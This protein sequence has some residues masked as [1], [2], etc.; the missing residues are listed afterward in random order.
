MTPQQLIK[1]LRLSDRLKKLVR[2]VSNKEAREALGHT[3]TA[4]SQRDYSG[5]A[6]EGFDLRGEA[7]G[8]YQVRRDNPEIDDHGKPENKYV[9]RPRS[10]GERWINTTPGALKP[11]DHVFVVE[12]PK[13]LLAV[14]AYFERTKFKNAKVIDLNGLPGWRVKESD[15]GPSH[16]NPDLLLLKGH[17]VT[18]LFDSNSFRD[19]LKPLVADFNAF[20]TEIGCQVDVGRIPALEGVNGPD[21]LLSRKDDKALSGVL[22]SAQ[23]LWYYECPAVSDYDP[24]DIKSDLLIE[25]LVANRSITL[26]ASPSENYKSMIAMC[27]SRS[28]LDKKDAFECSEFRVN[29]T[30]PGVLY[31]CPDMSHEMTILYASKFGL[32]GDAYKGRFRIRTMKQGEI[33]GPDHPTIIQAARAG[34]FIVLDTMNYFTLADDDN[35]PQRLNKFIQKVRHL[36]DAHGASGVL[37][38]VHPTKVGAMSNEVEVTQWVSGT[39]GKIGSVDTIFCMKKI[40]D[41][42]GTPVSVWLSREKSRPFLG[43]VLKPFTLALIDGQGSTLDKGR[44]PVSKLNAGELKEHMPKQNKGG[45]QGHPMKADMMKF[46]RNVINDNKGKKQLGREELLVKLNACKEFNPKAE[47]CGI[48]SRTIGNWL[49]ELKDDKNNVEALNDA[50]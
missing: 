6:F 41:E 11:K 13:A 46:I 32:H 23:P 50:A 49:K 44:L 24:K 37:M 42:S 2:T 7:R 36:V 27:M 12:G 8:V 43:V 3:G 15:D 31:M 19:D 38:L 16:P 28:L 39:Y 21:D 47:G 14:A 9:S 18:T 4:I 45:A 26:F 10:A 29:K 5:I 35:N 48:S 40:K 34:W 22:N 17:R 20:L 33:L 25:H 30:V 1:E